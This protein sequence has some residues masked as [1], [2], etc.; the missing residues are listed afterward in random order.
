MRK[1]VAMDLVKRLQSLSSTG[2]R[3]WGRGAAQSTQ[4]DDSE[5]TPEPG[6]NTAPGETAAARQDQLRN[7]T[8]E[9]LRE[10]SGKNFGS[11]AEWISWR[12]RVK[13]QK[14]PFA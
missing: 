5:E 4:Q 13:N 8:A 1:G 10:I 2:S 6:G 14:N 9:A 3:G 11:I 7:A 12:K